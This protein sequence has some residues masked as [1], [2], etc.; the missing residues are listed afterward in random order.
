MNAEDLEATVRP[1]QSQ[2][3]GSSRQGIPGRSDE[4]ALGRHRGACFLSWNGKRAITYRRIERIPD[5]WGTAV[6]VQSMV[7][8]NMGDDCATGV[9]F[10]RNPGTGENIS[11]AN[12]WSTRRA[13][14]WSRVSRTPAPLNEASQTDHNKDLSLS[15]KAMPKVYKEL[16]G[17]QKRLEKHYHDMQDI[18]FTIEKGWLSCCSAASASVTAPPRC[19][20]PSTW[21][22]RN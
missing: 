19:A 11:T 18:E 22:T 21:S 14:T 1:V 9:A 10:S 16:V 8:G 12:T 6:N 4:A 3:Q 20:W 5:E 15:G 17:I 2:D 13:R 7:F